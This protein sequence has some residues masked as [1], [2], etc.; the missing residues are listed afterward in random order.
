MVTP[1]RIFAAV[2]VLSVSLAYANSLQVGFELDDSYLIPSN[3]AIRSLANIPRF[4]WDPYMLTV[5]RNNIDLRPALSTTYAINYFLS[6]YRPWSYHVISLVIHLMAAGLVFVIVRDFLWREGGD[7]GAAIAAM[8][9]ALSPLNSQPA[10]LYMSGRS[11]SLATLFYL[12][13]F[14]MACRGRLGPLVGFH[15]L[16]LLSKA[17]AVTLP[18]AIVLYAVCYGRMARRRAITMVVATGALDIGYLLYRHLLLPSWVRDASH[19]AFMTPGIWLMSSWS[20]L[21]AYA[22]RFVLPADLS[23]DH[24]NV[25]AWSFWQPRAWLSLAVILAWIGLAIWYRKSWPLLAFGTGFFF[26]ALAPEHTVLALAEV[27]NDHRPYLASSLGLAPLLALGLMGPMLAYGHNPRRRGLI[28]ACVLLALVAMA[29]IHER[30]YVWQDSV[31][32]W[33]DTV[34]SG[35]G[36]CRAWMNLGVGLMGRGQYPEARANF[37]EA[38]RLCP[39]YAYVYANLSVLDGAEGHLA[40]S[41]THAQEAVRLDPGWAPARAYEAAALKRI[42]QTR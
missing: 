37:M 11:A 30:A 8:A 27:Q 29:A 10:S 19:G 42:G 21:L 9:F 6:G 17:V 26:L 20:A 14:L 24:E 36:N 2:L 35:P 40:S 23:I 41:L 39:A 1:A 5:V 3:P 13:G 28:P 33:R 4:F 38:K 34:R 15:A 22:R 12:A 32:L 31:R 25:I 7:L 18:G 16:A